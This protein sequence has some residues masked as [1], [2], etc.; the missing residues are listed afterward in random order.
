MAL[1]K[2]IALFVAAALFLLALFGVSPVDDVSALEQV[3][4]GG[5]ILAVVALL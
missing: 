2:R 5:L 4:L 1:A 3:A